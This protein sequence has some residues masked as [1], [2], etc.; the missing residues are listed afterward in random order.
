VTAFRSRYALQHRVWKRTSWDTNNA[1]VLL[2]LLLLLR[3]L[4]VDRLSMTCLCTS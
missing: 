3:T 2:L 1:R 4:S